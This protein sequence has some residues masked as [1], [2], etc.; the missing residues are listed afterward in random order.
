MRVKLGQVL[1]TSARSMHMPSTR[2]FARA[3]PYRIPV[4]L[5]VDRFRVYSNSIN[6]SATDTKQS[7]WNDLS[8]L[9]KDVAGKFMVEFGFLRPTDIQT[10]CFESMFRTNQSSGVSTPQYVHRHIAILAETG[11]GKTLAYLLPMLQ[12]LCSVSKVCNPYSLILLPNPELCDQ[13]SRVLQKLLNIFRISGKIVSLY[14]QRKKEFDEYIGDLSLGPEKSLNEPVFIIA[15]PGV[16]LQYDKAKIGSLIIPKL[17]WIV[18]DE[19]DLL[20]SESNSDE[21]PL[22]LM[23]CM[24]NQ[25]AWPFRL[26]ISAATFP[27]TRVQNW[28]KHF[29]PNL[30]FIRSNSL[31]CTVSSLKEHYVPIQK[32]CKDPRDLPPRIPP[33][34]TISPPIDAGWSR[35]QYREYNDQRQAYE[36]KYEDGIYRSKKITLLSLLNKEHPLLDSK[37][38]II[39]VNTVQKA[40]LL[41]KDL[42]EPNIECISDA[43]IFKLHKQVSYLERKSILQHMS[44]TR[45]LLEQSNS[46]RLILICTDYLSRGLDIPDIDA[47]I[48]FDF[49]SSAVDYLHRAG[50]TARIGK[51]GLMYSIL[52]PKDDRIAQVIARPDNLKSMSLNTGISSLDVSDNTLLDSNRSLEPGFSANRSLRQKLKRQEVK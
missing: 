45:A 41:H 8:L 30:H 9:H 32:Y 12:S 33:Q 31:H 39:F 40:D 14:P 37:K 21:L 5:S 42:T 15:T 13:T 7:S 48:Q 43:T 35:E 44:A 22:F 46:K 36:S 18:L 16:F 10:S 50:R 1:F 26:L 20:I 11:S 2:C 47:V 19:A 51:K 17:S 4:C 49:A 29:I 3:T 38:I 27:M 52:G 6:T 34:Y 23:H 25:T 24:K 28:A